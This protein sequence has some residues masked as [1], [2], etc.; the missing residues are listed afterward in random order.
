MTELA[1][2]VWLYPWDLRDADSVGGA[3][4]DAGVDTI[5]V[6][7]VY[8]SLL[9]AA[10]TD[11]VRRVI[12]LP[13]TSAYFRP[14]P[15]IWTGRTLRPRQSPLVSE[16]GDVFD[17]A[18]RVADRGGCAV[19]AWLVCVHDDRLVRDQ[20]ALAVQTATGD[21]MLGA[22]CLAAPEVREYV[23]RLMR[24][25]AN[26]ADAIQLESAHWLAQP[27]ARHAKIDGA[28]PVL[29][30]LLLSVCFCGRCGVRAARAGVDARQVAADLVAYWEQAWDGL[31][32]DDPEAVPGL[33]AY[34]SVRAATVTELITEAASTV[35][36]P[37][38][39][40]AFGDLLLHG[41]D[42]EAVAAA[43]VDVR[44]LAYGPAATVRAQL[45]RQ[46][47]RIDHLGLSMLPEHAADLDDAVAGVRAAA[48]SGVR[49]VRFYHYG[50]AGPRRREW[51]P[52]LVDAWHADLREGMHA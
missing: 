9:A 32:P 15:A 1:T 4:E 2:G 37:I 33:A 10:P 21:H 48:T 16:I 22:P 5:C 11:T 46:G 23:L 41:F 25:A 34:L 30:R 52:A 44:S 24:E 42:P 13:K 43:G 19:T 6:A 17:V 29:S 47:A 38:E 12:E 14:H 7:A 28:A 51:L 3:V 20:P 35:S 8:H 27:H 39:M 49:S 36:V 26:R 40:V 31:E 45:G 50:L 18:R